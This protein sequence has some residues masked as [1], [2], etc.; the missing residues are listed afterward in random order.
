MSVGAQWFDV[1]QCTTF[2]PQLILKCVFSLRLNVLNV[3]FS[4]EEQQ[5]TC[6][7]CSL[8]LPSFRYFPNIVRYDI[9]LCLFVLDVS[10][11]GT[12]TWAQCL[13]TK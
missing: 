9:V 8:E 10:L 5:I 6:V 7:S 12:Y 2:V 11:V 13:H 1:L 4:S 3:R